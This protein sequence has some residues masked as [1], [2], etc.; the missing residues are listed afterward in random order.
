MA[1][2]SDWLVTAVNHRLKQYKHPLL[3][4]L[5]LL[6]LNTAFFVSMTFYLADGPEL[7]EKF[8][9]LMDGA[10][11]MDD[12]DGAPVTD[13][14]VQQ[15]FEDIREKTA[16]TLTECGSIP[17]MGGNTCCTGTE[18]PS[19]T[20]GAGATPLPQCPAT[21][22]DAHIFYTALAS[23]CPP[24]CAVASNCP[25]ECRYTYKAVSWPDAIGTAGGYVALVDSF[26]TMI[27]IIIY[28][29]C[30][31]QPPAAV[32]SSPPLSQQRLTLNLVCPRA[33]VDYRVAVTA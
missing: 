5:V 22:D 25:P 7:D 21:D 16:F 10:P 19:Q 2:L 27:I 29:T 1:P 17:S 6:A 4:A 33:N 13:A 30:T 18:A 20:S 31:G 26:F 15:K 28:L 9:G 23:M 24:E 8:G 3:L 12:M 11:T 32:V 14:V